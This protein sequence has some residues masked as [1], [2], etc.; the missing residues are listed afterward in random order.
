VIV[1][2][3]RALAHVADLALRYSLGLPL[4]TVIVG[5]STMEQLEADLAMAEGFAPLSGP[6]QLAFFR[7]M[8]PLVKP[9]DMPCKAAD[10]GTPAHWESRQE[11]SGLYDW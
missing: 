11:P 5:C 1:I 10:W 7:E 2:G 3:H 8:L 4:T 9:E 6:E